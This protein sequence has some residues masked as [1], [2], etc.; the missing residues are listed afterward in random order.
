MVQAHAPQKPVLIVEDNADLRDAL[1]EL[2]RIAGYTV[3]TAENGKDALDRLHGSLRPG[4]VLL[5]LSMPVMDGWEFVAQKRK[6]PEIAP[7]PVVVLSALNGE[8]AKKLSAAAYLRKPVELPKLL[9]T[10]S[11]YC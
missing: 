11:A 9:Q 6:D 4:V 10:I 1:A 7:I 8:T 2:L 5:D 3:A